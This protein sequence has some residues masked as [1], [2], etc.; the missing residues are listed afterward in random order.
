MT[1]IIFKN[2]YV[3]IWWRV[4]KEFNLSPTETLLMVLIDGLSRKTGWCYA[5]KSRL[6][7]TINVSDQTVYSALNKLHSKELLEYGG[8]YISYK[9]SLIKPTEKWSNLIEEIKSGLNNF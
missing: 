2:T 3:K 6:A 8:K 4:V 1:E 5:S 7:Q 9:T